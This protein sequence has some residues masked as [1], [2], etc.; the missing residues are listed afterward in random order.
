LIVVILLLFFCGYGQA[1]DHGAGELGLTVVDGR[2][3]KAGKAYRGIGA[4]YFTCFSR[5][6][7]DG[8]DK[9]CRENFKL[10]AQSG[11]P[12]V[13]FMCCGFWPKQ[14]KLYLENKEEYFS[15]LDQL[16]RC[17]EE[18][19]L[20]LIPSLF[21]FYPTV[22]DLVG[23]HLG[24]LG[25]KDSKSIAF[26]RRYTEEVVQ[27][28]AKSP[29]IWG[30]EF[31]NEH[32]L[33]ADLPEAHRWRQ[34][35]LYP[36]LGTPAQRTELDD[37]TFP[38]LQVAFAAFAETVRTF[39]AGRFISTGNAVPRPSAYHNVSEHTWTP[40]TREQYAQMLLRDNPDPFDTISV[41]IYHEPKAGYGGGAAT[42]G[43]LIGIT[44]GFADHAHKPLF[45]GEFGAD[46]QLGPEKERE[47]FEE[48]IAAIEKYDVPLSAFWVYDNPNMEADWNVRFDNE[49]SYMI[50]LIS[51]ANARLQ[52]K[53]D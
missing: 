48:F 53:S 40:D 47:C 34:D 7:L 37:L 12:F 3:M 32:V 13:R 26:I 30:W 50:A 36:H 8:N 27:R 19:D 17:A 49:R 29:A 39:D 5:S 2:L 23:E 42:V 11:I 9:S 44:K 31:G 52:K 38:H 25:N 43:Q 22:P 28:Y 18:N 41:H 33:A 24:E 51:A 46:K 1:A 45:L 10:L 21:W 16:V 20:G 14:Q 35:N 4:N 6:I 15:R